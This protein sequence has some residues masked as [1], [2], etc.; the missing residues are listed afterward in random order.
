MTAFVLGDRASSS[1]VTS[2]LYSGTVTSTNT[3]TAPYCMHGAM[4]VGNPQATVMTSSPLR[5]WRSPSSGEV[6]AEK[7]S[8]LAEEPEL[9]SEQY[10]TPSHSA[11]RFSNLRA[12]GPAV[13]QKSS[14]E[15]TRLIISAASK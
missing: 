9:V 7:A 5:I 6:S 4:V 14:E 1:L 10:L 2:M 11:N 13:S 8:R 15:S 3:G 12:H